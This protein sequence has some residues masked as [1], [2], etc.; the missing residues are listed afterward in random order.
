ME[1]KVCRRIVNSATVMDAVDIENWLR[2]GEIVM[3]SGYIW[4]DNSKAFLKMI[5]SIN[6]AGATALFIKLGRFIDNL[7]PET[8]ALAEKLNFPII[9]ASQ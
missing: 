1:E 6:N 3:T 8:Y 5:E 2:G 9:K 4:K 7:S